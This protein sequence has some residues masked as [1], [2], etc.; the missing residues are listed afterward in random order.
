MIDTGLEKVWA[1]NWEEAVEFWEEEEFWG[2]IAALVSSDTMKGIRPQAREEEN[3]EME[4]NEDDD[5]CDYCIVKKLISIHVCI[6]IAAHD[7]CYKFHS[8]N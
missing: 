8:L 2:A 5:E 3:S 1:T 6:Y 4:K 7:L